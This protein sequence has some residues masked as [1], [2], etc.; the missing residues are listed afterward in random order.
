MALNSPGPKVEYYNSYQGL[1]N[2]SKPLL[3]EEENQ[4][5]AGRVQYYYMGK[6][7]M[8]LESSEKGKRGGEG[9]GGSNVAHRPRPLKN[10]ANPLTR[11]TTPFLILTVI[12]S[13][14]QLE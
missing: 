3:H 10:A 11:T 14:L 5:A 6:H 1:N 2:L 13:S 9:G 12:I 8:K 4:A 7:V